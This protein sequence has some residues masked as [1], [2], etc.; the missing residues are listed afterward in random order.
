M[1]PTRF[2]ATFNVVS[3]KLVAPPTP[4]LLEALFLVNERNWK[5]MSSSTAAQG[6]Q[7]E[8]KV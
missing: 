1:N 4:A 7:S 2:D 6:I 8:G 5:T 3:S